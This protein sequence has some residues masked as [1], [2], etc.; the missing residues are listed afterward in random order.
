MN[1]D[2]I[3][4]GDSI[5]GYMVCSVEFLYVVVSAVSL[6]KRVAGYVKVGWFSSVDGPAANFQDSVIQLSLRIKVV[7]KISI[8]NL[9]LKYHCKLWVQVAQ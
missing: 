4:L 6:F 5:P 9:K 2:V 8:P 7:T 1:I 3:E